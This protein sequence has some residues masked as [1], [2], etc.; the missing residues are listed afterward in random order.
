MLFIE[1]EV[2]KYEYF[3]E[4]ALEKDDVLISLLITCFV[5][6]ILKKLFAMSEN[7][8]LCA[9]SNLYSTAST[10]EQTSNCKSCGKQVFQMEQVKAER[11]VWHKNC[12]RCKECNKQLT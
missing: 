11:A 6:I 2:P 9:D 5:F 10:P 3:L 7:Y 8:S 1:F 4:T 12:F